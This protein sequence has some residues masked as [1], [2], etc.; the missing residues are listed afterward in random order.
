MPSARRRR[1][2]RLTECAYY[3]VES[4]MSEHVLGMCPT[5]SNHLN[6]RS[7]TMKHSPFGQAGIVLFVV[8]S[9]LCAA[10]AAAPQISGIV[11][12]AGAIR[13]ERDGHEIATLIPGLFESGWRYAAM[14]A[15]KAGQVF[16][17]GVHR[18]KITA[19]GGTAVD[20]ELRLSPQHGRVGLEYRLTP[21]ANI[22]LNSLHVSLGLPAR[23]WAGGSFTADKHSGPL[24]A[25]FGKT[26]LYSTSM[27]S[28]QLVGDDGAALTLGFAEPTQVLV[29]DDRQWGQSFSVR[30]GPQLNGKTWAA[31]KS[32]KLAFS[33]TSVGGLALEEDRPVTVKAGPTWLPL[34]VTLDIEPDSALDFSKVIPR[35]TPAGKFGRVIVNSAGKFAFSDRP[36]EA[37]RFYGVNLCF[38]AHYLDHDVADQLAERLYRLGYNALRIHHYERDLVD[39]SSADQIRFLPER[40][41]QFDYLFAALKQRGIYV[42]TD[43]FVSRSVPQARIYPGTDGA[44]EM[45]DYKMAVHVNERA[46]ADY[47]AFSQALLDHVNPYTK[48][49]YAD[50]PTL[51]WLSLVNE[52]NP[53]NFIG[54][55]KGPLRNDVQNAWNRWLAARFHD[56]SALESA[57]GNLPDDQDPAKGNVPLQN[58]RA[59]SPAAV[60]FNV[61]L[62]EVEQD[63]FDRTRQFLR[64]ELHCDALLTDMNAWTNPV[65]MQAVRTSFDYVDDHFY[66]DHPRFLERPWSLPSS[67]PNTSPIADGAPGG[68]SC[69]FTRLHGKPFT[70]TEFNYSSPGRFR[71]VGG[72]LTGAL[73]ALQD[74]D[75]VWRFAYSHS[76]DSIPKPRP[77]NYFDV[78]SDPLNQAAERASLCLFLRGDLEPAQ[79]SV[80]ITATDSQLLKTPTTSRDKTPSWNAVAWLTRVGWSVADEPSLRV[81]GQAVLPIVGGRIDPFAD[82]AGQHIVDSLRENGWLSRKNRTELTDNRMVSENDQLTIDAPTNTF[83]LDTARTA[84]GFAPAGARIE[85]QRATIQIHETDATVW[86]S[87]LDGQPIASSKRLLI[88]HLTDLQNTGARY[89]DR[90]RKVLLSWGSLPHLAQSGRATVAL[91]VP[92]AS[93]A[94]VYG[95]STSGKRTSEIHSTRESN[96]LVIP[97]SVSDHGKAR[98]LYEVVLP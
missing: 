29:Q 1:R 33:L 21:Q 17:G 59:T 44:I 95:L 62:A 34:D 4:V 28:L 77:L 74:W 53:G 30:V 68:R 43:L 81:P 98:M 73:A 26:I 88:T 70:I 93:E 24:P 79:H 25:Q 42:T 11:S 52:D 27:K 10:S 83:V 94:K 46:Y 82:D 14:G 48:M 8:M 55:L 49:R 47:L 39:R 64:N 63:F 32:L 80:A 57:L 31:G 6:C 58:V 36:D 15:A 96:Q 72:I 3:F 67:C 76:R 45:N 90:A 50:D 40:L 41:D 18:G 60:Q 38:S 84:G 61:F 35:H 87:S 37:V 69:A 12:P 51:S 89:A 56:R 9:T 85:T 22:E 97:L 75:G 19:P 5:L 13:I 86:I 66:V 92:N 71:G 91:R 16:T 65:Q 54:R 78:A 7:T 2:L 23:D 20:V